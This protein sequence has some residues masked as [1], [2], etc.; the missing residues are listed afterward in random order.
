MSRFSSTVRSSIRWYCWKTNP[1][2][3]LC[4]SLRCFTESL[5][6]G[7]PRKSNSPLHWPSSI[8]RMASRV[9]FPAPEGPM[10]VTNSPGAT[11]KFTW[12]STKVFVPP[13]SYAFSRFR[14]EIM[15]DRVV[16]VGLWVVV[17]GDDNP[18]PTTHQPLSFRSQRLH[19]VHPPPR[20]GPGRTRP[21]PLRPAARHRA[22]HRDARS[23]GFTSNSSATT[24]R[25]SAEG[26]G[27]P[28][29][30]AD[31]RRADA[32][33]TTRPDDVGRARHPA[34]CARRSPGCAARRRRR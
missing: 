8:P 24:A 28:D 11:S 1:M 9:D 19:R 15:T 18:P 30:R 3:F 14:I 10:M 31:G 12:R 27:Q 20:G 6:T 22:G 34:R 23:T 26:D 33:A 16:G 29:Q 17:G 21:R 2:Y 32:C 25:P 7:S 5:C 4:S 13:V